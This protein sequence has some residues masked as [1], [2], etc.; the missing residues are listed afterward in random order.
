MHTT[1]D[2]VLRAPPKRPKRR[3]LVGILAA[4]VLLVSVSTAV[5][6][7]VEEPT[8]VQAGTTDCVV[9]ILVGG[10]GF[11][12]LW[13]APPAGVAAWLGWGS[14]LTGTALSVQSCQ[15]S[16]LR[17][18]LQNHQLNN[19]ATVYFY[20]IAWNRAYYGRYGSSSGPFVSGGGGG[21]CSG[22]W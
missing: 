15:T 11:I 12:S 19:C 5:T 6:T 17:S 4:L 13:L 3:R 10:A 14:A 2:K 16:Y 8:P 9:G 21:G 22:S 1:T 20:G 18:V 7:A